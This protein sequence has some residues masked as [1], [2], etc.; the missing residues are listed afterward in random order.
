MASNRGIF[1]QELVVSRV[2]LPFLRVGTSC[3]CF[4]GK[5]RNANKIR[6][7]SQ[8]V[9]AFLFLPARNDVLVVLQYQQKADRP[10]PR[11]RTSRVSS[12]VRISGKFR[13][14]MMPVTS[15]RHLASPLAHPYAGPIPFSCLLSLP[16][17]DPP[18]LL[19]ATCS[20]R[21]SLSEPTTPILHS[22][23]W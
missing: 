22:V 6:R 18:C 16:S 23:P 11:V 21:R 13:R 7:C 5:K 15:I 2:V 8:F 1:E 19:P 10:T 4:V 9:L 12:W 3:K 17:S 14:T 20:L